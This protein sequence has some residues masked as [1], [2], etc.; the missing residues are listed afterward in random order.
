M[1]VAGCVVDL[2]GVLV[3]T[4]FCYLVGGGDLRRAVAEGEVAKGQVA[5]ADCPHCMAVAE[6]EPPKRRVSETVDPG[7]CRE[8]FVGAAVDGGI[9]VD[10][11]VAGI[12]E[13][14][15]IIALPKACGDNEL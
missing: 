9:V 13:E 10:G 1:R 2:E 7:A 15:C 14:L 11:A 12:R 6:P 4:A 5:E 8:Q 3:G